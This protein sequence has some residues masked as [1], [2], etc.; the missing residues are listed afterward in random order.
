MNTLTGREG[1]ALGWYYLWAAVISAVIT[2]VQL[3]VLQD[4]HL[5]VLWGAWAVLFA[6]CF[7]AQATP[8]AWSQRPN[9]ALTVMQSVTTATIPALL[10]LAG[11]WR[12]TPLA[13]VLGAQV[14]VVVVYAVL[15][16]RERRPA[17]HPE[18][19]PHT[20]PLPVTASA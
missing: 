19:P 12:Q 5:A 14:A 3:L 13:L 16:V 9:G 17:L 1:T 7:L 4:G 18:P 11:W 10:D 6:A 15:M 20:G 8:W 2:L